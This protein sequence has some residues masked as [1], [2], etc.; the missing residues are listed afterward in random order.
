MLTKA[1]VKEIFSPGGDYAQL[2]KFFETATKEQVD[3]VN[4]W[5]DE[6][7]SPPQLGE[8]LL[9]GLT[10]DQTVLNRVIEE[11]TR[12]PAPG[13]DSKSA[14]N[15]IRA[16]RSNMLRRLKKVYPPYV[17]FTAEQASQKIKVSLYEVASYLANEA[18]LPGSQ[19]HLDEASGKYYIMSMFGAG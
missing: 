5:I 19:I 14:R 17:P 2:E 4:A 11:A 12:A 6:I 16:L 10:V 8:D 1:Q 3:Q 18:R 13:A 7:T 9:E 15:R